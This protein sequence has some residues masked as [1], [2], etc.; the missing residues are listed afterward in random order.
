MHDYTTLFDFCHLEEG[1]PS[2][3]GS[4]NFLAVQPYIDLAHQIY[5]N[6]HEFDVLNPRGWDLV[7]SLLC[8]AVKQIGTLRELVIFVGHNNVSETIKSALLTEK[9]KSMMEKDLL[10]LETDT[11]KSEKELEVLYWK[12]PEISMVQVHIERDFGR[13]MNLRIDL[14]EFLESRKDI[15]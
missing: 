13:S 9:L 4:L 1:Q 6:G 7:S 12:I 3:R 11:W 10:A 14:E 8:S 2:I 5:G 15:S